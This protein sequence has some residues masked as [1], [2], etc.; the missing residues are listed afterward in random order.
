MM[1][2]SEI[3]KRFLEFFAE[4]G[5]AILPSVPLLPDNDGVDRNITLF[6]I[7]GMQPL[8]PYLLGETHP[9]GRRLASSQKCF[10]TVD[11]DEVG[12]NT[13]GTFF[14][15]MGNWS[16]GDYY[17]KESILWSYEF[18]TS[19]EKGLGLNPSRLYVTVFAGSDSVPRDEEAAEIWSEIF[20]DAGLDP[21]GRIFYLGSKSNW[22][23]AGP[24]S[25]AGPSTEMFYDFTGELTYG[26]THEEF[27]QADEDQKLVEIWNNVFM[28]YRQEAGKVVEDLPVKNVDT[29]AGLERVVAVVQGK[30]SI[31]ETDVFVPIIEAI[32][33]GDTANARIIA[34]HI[35]S[36]TFL[37]AEG[38]VPSNTDQGYVLRRLLRR[39]IVKIADSSKLV[40]LVDVVV[41]IYKD[42]YPELVD[43]IDQVK[44]V[45]QKEVNVFEK[46]LEKG[47]R[48][49]EK[50]ER[51][52]FVLFT[53]YGFPLEMTVELAGE[54]GEK[55]DIEDFNKKMKE[56]QSLSRTGAEQKFK[57]GLA[58]HSSETVKL[59][60]AHHLLLAALQEVVNP[61][62]KQ[63]GSNITGER[64]RMDFSFDRKLTDEEKQ[65]VEDLVNEKIQAG[66]N[67]V[68]REMPLEEAVEIGAEM[69][70]GTKYPDNVSVYFIEDADGDIFS[71]E[72][73]GGPHVENTADLG[74]FKI[75]KE[76]ASSA[77]VRRIKAIL[78]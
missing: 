2:S 56:H 31:F 29:G 16:L 12:D 9:K 17:K 75:K 30:T 73:C 62:I 14:E 42:V 32:G 5:H 24:D 43:A 27:L 3:R 6:N 60:T 55:I 45:I 54:K 72:F 47:L 58:D 53:T 34:D 37:V 10:R 78:Q 36:A 66:L 46:T 21:M 23:T 50:G 26:L 20:T 74:H 68:Q 65:Q 64:M 39:S 48:K 77:G 25:P 61:D 57:G 44:S 69:E 51:D 70:F 52:A 40:D 22:W 4:R 67:V 63:R 38:L 18:L 1:T 11:I 59:H 8:M 33:D 15:M 49:F 13:H 19:P 7:A 28:V 35:K 71:K 76:K 41:L